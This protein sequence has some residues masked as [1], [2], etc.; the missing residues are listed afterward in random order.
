FEVDGL[1]YYSTGNILYA[2]QWVKKGFTYRTGPSQTSFTLKMFNNAPGG[3]GNDWA[4]DDIS[5]AT[6]T[7]NLTMIPSGNANV[8][9]GNQVDMACVVRSY[10][11]NYTHYSWERSTDGGATWSP[12]GV[13]GV[14]SPTLVSGEYQYTATYPS[15]IATES[16]HLTRYRIRIASTSANL[17]NTSCSFADMTTIVVW[18]N[19]CQWVLDSKLKSFTGQVQNGYGALQWEIE[20]EADNIVYEIER[21]TNQVHFEKIG[22]VSGTAAGRNNTYHFTD[23]LQLTGHTYYRI[24]MVEGNRT[25]YS[26]IILLTVRDL[27]Y[28]L[29]SV[30][31]PFHETLSFELI[32][33]ASGIAAI[34][35]VDAYGRLIKQVREPYIKGLNNLR[36][37][38]MGSLA[39]GTYTLR[40]QVDNQV[41]NAKVIKSN[42]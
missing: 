13:S 25:Q 16:S 14:G 37:P 40:V 24:K 41:Y 2:G 34:T 39:A 4:L 42:R 33:P 26:K 20:Q 38:N 9:M 7:P 27:Q 8:C 36:I 12:T 23:P 19:N 18:V 32:A 5:V 35:L 17:A 31:N 22:Q 21:S 29:R 28:E 15:F 3:G 10:F 1:D 11:P 6:C 30:V